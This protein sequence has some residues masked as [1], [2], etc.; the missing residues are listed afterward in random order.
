MGDFMV[1]DFISLDGKRWKLYRKTKITRYEYPIKNK[2]DGMFWL[3]HEI[4]GQAKRDK[5]YF[6]SRIPAV[7]CSGYSRK[8]DGTL[9]IKN[10]LK[11]DPIQE[12]HESEIYDMINQYYFNLQRMVS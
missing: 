10:L 5:K 4:I 11:V 6:D 9:N 3:L 1:E 12:L 2:K 7:G 8:I